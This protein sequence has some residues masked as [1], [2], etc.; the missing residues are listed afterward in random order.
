ME[1]FTVKDF[2]LTNYTDIVAG[3]VTKFYPSE[4]GNRLV[5][6][7]DGVSVE[8]NKEVVCGLPW[9]VDCWLRR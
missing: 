5:I 9:M 6:E 4:D 7:Q 1:Q 8:L 2:A 3:K